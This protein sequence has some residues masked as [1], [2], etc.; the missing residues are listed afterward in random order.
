MF[1]LETDAEAALLDIE[2]VTTPIAFVKEKLFP[3]AEKNVLGFLAQ[4]SEDE[5][6]KPIVTNLREEYAAQHLGEVLGPHTSDVVGYVLSLMREDKKTTALKKLQGKIWAAGYKS[7]ELVGEVY[8]D[9]VRALMR[10]K[11]RGVDLRIF[12]SG[13][14]EA[15]KL[16]FSHTERGNLTYLFSGHYDT[17]IGDKK[18]PTSYSRIATAW[19]RSPGKILFLSDEVPELNAAREAGMQTGL[20]IRLGNKPQPANEYRRISTFDEIR[21]LN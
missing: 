2:G 10:W 6:I 21:F 1:S 8:P 18:A 15:Q 13:S 16:L 17:E 11:E 4:N 9:V 7:G 14:V 5:G 3:Y 12:S 19:G 20:C